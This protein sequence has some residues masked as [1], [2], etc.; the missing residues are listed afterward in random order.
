M[1]AAAAKYELRQAHRLTT[2]DFQAARRARLAHRSRRD[3][4]R[5]ERALADRC[6]AHRAR[7]RRL[8]REAAGRS[9]P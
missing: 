9:E 7:I 1:T 5:E 3:L 8:E 6:A 2:R 4:T